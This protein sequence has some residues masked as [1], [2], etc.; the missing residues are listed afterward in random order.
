M[1]FARDPERGSAEEEGMSKPDIG[2]SDALLA[3]RSQRG[4]SD[5]S[6]MVLSLG[7]L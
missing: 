1:P 4:F 6:S 5:W 7:L 3:P 2:P